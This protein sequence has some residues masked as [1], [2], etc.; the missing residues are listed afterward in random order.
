[1]LQDIIVKDGGLSLAYLAY[2]FQVAE[3]DIKELL[4]PGLQDFSQEQLFFLAFAQTQ[5]SAPSKIKAGTRG[6]YTNPGEFFLQTIT[7][8]SVDFARQWKCALPSNPNC[9][10]F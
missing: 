5:C 6:R 2:Q 1:M 3:E 10:I 4:L 9:R 8:N 7:R